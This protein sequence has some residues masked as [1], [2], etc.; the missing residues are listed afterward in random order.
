MAGASYVAI[1]QHGTGGVFNITSNDHLGLTY[2]ALGFA[3]VENGTFVYY[4]PED[5]RRSGDE[6]NAGL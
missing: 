5:W 6:G 1:M 2:E 4:P 3:R